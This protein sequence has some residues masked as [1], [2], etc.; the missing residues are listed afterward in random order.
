MSAPSR[1]SSSNKN[2]SGSA[3]DRRRRK[4]WLL[5]TFRADTDAWVFRFTDG[6]CLVVEPSTWPSETLLEPYVLEKDVKACR[7]YRCGDLLIFETLTV[8]R[9]VP[10]RKGGT[11]RRNN[12]RPACGPCNFGHNRKDPS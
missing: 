1:R 6:S 8:D 9:I 3:E 7:C 12:I 2:E 5:D 11:Y 10:G 4:L